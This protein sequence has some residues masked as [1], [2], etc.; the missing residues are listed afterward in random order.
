[1]LPRKNGGATSN[2]S[3]MSRGVPD[4]PLSDNHQVPSHWT[5][6][7]NRVLTVYLPWEEGGVG[8]E[9]SSKT[10]VQQ[11]KTRG[12]TWHPTLSG[13][14]HSAPAWNPRPPHTPTLWYT[15][16]QQY[17]FAF[18]LATF[19]HICQKVEKSKIHCFKWKVSSEPKGVLDTK[20]ASY[21]PLISFWFPF[22]FIMNIIFCQSINFPSV[23]SPAF[24]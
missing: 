20:H 4:S 6:S 16:G 8:R 13:K 22:A 23:I 1:M 5:N 12:M 21:F 19:S 3:Q 10:T 17:C 14:L 15:A 7:G 24:S 18:N 2:M 9:K 11:R